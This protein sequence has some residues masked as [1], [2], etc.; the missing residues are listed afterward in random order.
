VIG[1]RN[2]VPAL[3]VWL[4]RGYQVFVSP[5]LPGRCRYYPSC[6]QYAIDALREYGVLRGLVLASWRVLRCNPFSYG[7]YDPVERQ[8]LFSPRHKSGYPP[9]GSPAEE[10]RDLHRSHHVEAA[11]SAPGPGAGTALSGDPACHRDGS[12]MNTRLSSKLTV[13]RTVR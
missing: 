3:L 12:A 9:G 5:G 11:E 2:P 10:T 4:V 7:G 8:T 1:H 6:S 13:G